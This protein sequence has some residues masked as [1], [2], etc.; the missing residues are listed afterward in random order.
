M[1]GDHGHRT[2]HAHWTTYDPVE[3]PLHT[4]RGSEVGGPPA[5]ATGSWHLRCQD[6]DN[7]NQRKVLD[8]D[9]V[10]DSD[11]ALE[12]VNAVEPRDRFMETIT[13][14]LCRNLEVDPTNMGKLSEKYVA[15]LL[16]KQYL[17]RDA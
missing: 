11:I 13:Y 15:R 2:E 9:R 14:D 10:E 5:R 1:H 16:E 3:R 4:T 17:T 7:D 8:N 12:E 6:A